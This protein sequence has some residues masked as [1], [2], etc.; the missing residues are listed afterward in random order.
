MLTF[1]TAVFATF[2]E[3]LDSQAQYGVPYC[4]ALVTQDGW[5]RP[6]S[7]AYHNDSSPSESKERPL[8]QGSYIVLMNND[9]KYRIISYDTKCNMI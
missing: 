5:L 1:H 9:R 8:A 7:P 3:G 6:R 4:P 2:D